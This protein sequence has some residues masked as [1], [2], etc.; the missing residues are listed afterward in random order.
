MV[1]LS[2]QGKQSSCCVLP[3][4]REEKKWKC[5]PPTAKSGRLQSKQTA[6]NSGVYDRYYYSSYYQFIF[7]IFTRKFTA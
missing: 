4:K 5:S 3:K 6:L 2:I 7:S 1:K